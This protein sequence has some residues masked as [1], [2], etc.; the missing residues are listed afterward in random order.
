LFQNFGGYIGNIN[1]LG[2]I[3]KYERFRDTY[4]KNPSKIIRDE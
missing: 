4:L 3:S 1:N 2:G